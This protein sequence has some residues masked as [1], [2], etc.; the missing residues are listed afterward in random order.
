M[1]S[2]SSSSES[3]TSKEKQPI[4]KIVP[5]MEPVRKIKT[6]TKQIVINLS[7]NSRKLNSDEI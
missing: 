4:R 5:V 3:S 2:D 7:S 1:S 6:N